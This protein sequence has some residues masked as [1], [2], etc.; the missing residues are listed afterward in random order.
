MSLV[1]I[2]AKNVFNGFLKT[3]KAASCVTVS[4]VLNNID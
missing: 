3:L 2:V 1:S 4:S